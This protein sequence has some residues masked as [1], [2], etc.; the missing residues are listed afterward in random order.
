VTAA[1]IFALAWDADRRDGEY[2]VVCNEYCG[3]QHHNMA[4]R[5]HVTD[6]VQISP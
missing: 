1:T 6:K 5:I 3:V 2:L 4:G